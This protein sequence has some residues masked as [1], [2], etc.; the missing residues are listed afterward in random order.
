MSAD[1]LHARCLRFDEDR[2]A[3]PNDL[4]HAQYAAL[5]HAV[6]A[7]VWAVTQD[8]DLVPDHAY[9]L[10]DAIEQLPTA[11]ERY[12]ATVAVLGALLKTHVLPA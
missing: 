8:A 1:A 3:D 7:A 5:V 2:G 4:A 11:G 10:L 12:T 9:K 6:M